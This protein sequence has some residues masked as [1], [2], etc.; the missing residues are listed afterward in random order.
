MNHLR[1]DLPNLRHG[2]EIH[3][4]VRAERGG[5]VIEDWSQTLIISVSRRLLVDNLSVDDNGFLPPLDFT[6]IILSPSSVRLE[7]T[8]NNPNIFVKIL[9]LFSGLHYIINVKQL[10]SKTGEPLFQRQIKVVANNFALGNLKP[11]EHYEMTIRTALSP[12]QMSDT[13]AIVEITMPKDDEY[14]EVGNLV[15]S[16]HFQ[17][18]GQGIVNLTWDVPPHIQR[19]IKSY[20]VEYKEMNDNNWQ[21]LQFI[22]QIPSATL[23]NLKSGT[24]YL[25]KIKTTLH[26]DVSTESG[27]FK[28]RTPEVLMNP[29]NKV[30][31]IYTNEM[32][33]VRL[34]W[35]LEPS[36]IAI[37]EVFG[38]DVYLTEDKDLPE[39]QWKYLYSSENS[40][41]V[42]AL[43][44]G[45]TYY[46]K[47]NVRKTDGTV[48]R[49][50]VY[51]TDRQELPLQ[52]WNRM[53]IYNA[54]QVISSKNF[55]HLGHDH[56]QP[57]IVRGLG[58]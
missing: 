14:F 41:S 18:S 55:Y 47:I 8:P 9:K 27:H 10:T 2:D 52:Q 29:I 53:D 33:S 26:G 16:S 42:N 49:S 37:N 51:Y 4:Q 5:H 54:D 40:V 13:A 36:I 39:S 58:D 22:G 56:P 1:L 46:I 24:E 38:Y 57:R 50:T 19:K 23:K 17:S 35:V 25:L 31:V 3:A 48:V 28:F 45:T 30:D 43:K 20:D 12:E 7:W 11:G 6:A 15:I 21:K 32:D 44:S 34:H